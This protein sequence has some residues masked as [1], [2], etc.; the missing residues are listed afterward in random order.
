MTVNDFQTVVHVVT[1]E[2]GQRAWEVSPTVLAEETDALC[3]LMVCK[4]IQKA[5][6]PLAGLGIAT[7]G[8]KK[9]K[10]KLL[11]LK[12][13]STCSPFTKMGHSCK[14]TFLDGFIKNF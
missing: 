10:S 12:G 14:E 11:L 13:P 1:L 7:R 6:L 4:H 3:Y 8:E 2:I 5:Q 9:T